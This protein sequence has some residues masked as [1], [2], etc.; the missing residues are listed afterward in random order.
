MWAESP[1]R[2]QKMALNMAG[3]GMQE[4]PD[5]HAFFSELLGSG[6]ASLWGLNISTASSADLESP[7]DRA[8]SGKADV[9]DLGKSKKKLPE[10]L[11]YFK[12]AD[13]GLVCIQPSVGFPAP[14]IFTRCCNH[15]LLEVGAGGSEVEC[16]S[17]IYDKFEDS[18]K[19]TTTVKRSTLTF[20]ST[21]QLLGKRSL[22][23]HHDGCWACTHTSTARHFT[24]LG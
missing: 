21:Q 17:Q 14:D 8:G 18:L 10:G 11:G 12:M 13:A 3:R 15:S 6:G 23:M 1:L 22:M 5:R 9:T 2:W 20:Y 7:Q 24:K 19:T 4:P 16:H